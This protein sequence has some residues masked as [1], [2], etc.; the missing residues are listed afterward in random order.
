MHNLVLGFLIED[1]FETW[2]G[3]YLWV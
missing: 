1:N 3:I 2:S